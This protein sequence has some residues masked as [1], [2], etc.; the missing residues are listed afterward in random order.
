MH[1][2]WEFI[3]TGMECWKRFDILSGPMAIV[4]AKVSTRGGV[5]GIEFTPLKSRYPTINI[6]QNEHEAHIPYYK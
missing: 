6:A 5:S 3:A 4:H 1:V 2:I